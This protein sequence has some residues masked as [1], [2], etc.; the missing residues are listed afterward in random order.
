MRSFVFSVITGLEKEVMVSIHRT[1]ARDTHESSRMSRGGV[2]ACLR[3][4]TS[5]RE[6][7]RECVEIDCAALRLFQ[8]CL[9]HDVKSVCEISGACAH[10]AYR[11]D[12][13]MSIAENAVVN[14]PALAVAGRVVDRFSATRH[15]RHAIRT[16]FLQRSDSRAAESCAYEKWAK[17]NRLRVAATT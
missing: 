5:L 3:D 4:K 12:A 1:A 8:R 10:V 7:M 17:T 16:L 11:H 15:R 6:V 9:T 2:R 14:A 13:S